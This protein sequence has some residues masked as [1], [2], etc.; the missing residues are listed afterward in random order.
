MIIC[1]FFT[2]RNQKFMG[3]FSEN[4]AKFAA[5]AGILSGEPDALAD[6][7]QVPELTQPK[8][9]QKLPENERTKVAAQALTITEKHLAHDAKAAESFAKLK[10][11]QQQKIAPSAFERT[12]LVAVGACNK[13]RNYADLL[14][15]QQIQSFNRLNKLINTESGGAITLSN[16]QELATWLK[17]QNPEQLKQVFEEINAVLQNQNQEPPAVAPS[18][19]PEKAATPVSTPKPAET[20][21]ATPEKA[22]EGNQDLYGQPLDWNKRDIK[23]YDTEP[24]HPDLVALFEGVGTKGQKVMVQLRQEAYNEFQALCQDFNTHAPAKIKPFGC[25]VTEGFRT[26]GKQQG[27]IEAYKKRDRAEGTNM[28]ALAN[29]VG[30]SEHHLGTTIDLHELKRRG[31]Y[32]WFVGSSKE[33]TKPDFLPRIVEHGYV[34]TVAGEPWHFRYVGKEQAKAYWKKFGTTIIEDHHRTLIE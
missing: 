31:M 33:L 29:K 10:P 21:P 8:D 16:Y 13:L 17:T 2:K 27:I 23:Y 15:S 5:L 25:Y 30:Y 1:Q 4:F 24:A 22:I 34:P 20:K 9:F 3:K 7:K 14:D 6:K 32:D 12:R 28:A 11:E 26:L 19:K 18:P